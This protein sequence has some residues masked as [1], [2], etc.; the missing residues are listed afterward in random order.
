M[1]E[2]QPLVTRLKVY[3]AI[4]KE[5]DYQ[6]LLWGGRRHDESHSVG[7]FIVYMEDYLRKTK[8]AYTQKGNNGAMEQLRKAVALG[9]CCF[10]V[11]GVP[12]RKLEL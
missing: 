5:R 4:D 7:D 1:A 12:D 2:I 3:E 6:D 10:E 11:H 9:V 8:E